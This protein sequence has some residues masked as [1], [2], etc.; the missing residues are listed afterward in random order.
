MNHPEYSL[1]MTL[2]GTEGSR[3]NPSQLAEAAGRK[4]R[5]HHAAWQ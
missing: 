4:V 3:L 1:L 2:Y 5:E